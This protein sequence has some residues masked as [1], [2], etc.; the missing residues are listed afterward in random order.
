MHRGTAPASVET[1]PL[2]LTD[3]PIKPY[4]PVRDR[5]LMQNLTPMVLIVYSIFHMIE[6]KSFT[7]PMH[8]SM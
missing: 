2:R 3:V 1:K 4:P 7:I 8:L 6:V 5:D